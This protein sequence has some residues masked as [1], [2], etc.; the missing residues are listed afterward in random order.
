MRHKEKKS[1]GA[2]TEGGGV[3]GAMTLH[4][5]QDAGSGGCGSAL[6]RLS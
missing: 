2:Q 3:A 6:S 5:A 1:G 4:K